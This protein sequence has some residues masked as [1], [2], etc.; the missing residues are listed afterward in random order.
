VQGVPSESLGQEVQ[1]TITFYNSAKGYGFIWLDAQDKDKGSFFFHQSQV[2]DSLLSSKLSCYE[3][4]DHIPVRFL[5]GPK[6]SHKQYPT[7][8]SLEELVTP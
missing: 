1:G 2:K 7:A 3:H 5:E 8:L 6:A 4:G